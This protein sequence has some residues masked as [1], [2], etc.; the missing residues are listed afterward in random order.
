M[1][2][3]IELPFKD[4]VNYLVEEKLVSQNRW[5]TNYESVI[6]YNDGKFYKCEYERGSTENQEDD[7]T[8]YEDILKCVEVHKVP[9]T[10]EVWEE[11]KV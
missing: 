3:T 8:D 5:T 4:V 1:K 6:K 11:V 7:G 9:K 2:N 10:V